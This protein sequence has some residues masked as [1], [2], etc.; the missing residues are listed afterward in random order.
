[1]EEAEIKL[2]AN[3]NA[4]ALKGTEKFNGVDRVTKVQSDSAENEVD[5]DETGFASDP[6]Y[7]PLKD[8]EGD[9]GID[10]IISDEEEREATTEKNTKLYTS[11][12]VVGIN[13]QKSCILC[14]ST[15][16]DRSIK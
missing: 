14:K 5:L 8:D 11:T 15:S 3:E 7:E 12:G 16:T 6:D 1:M 4:P 13:R 2:K 9:D 10:H